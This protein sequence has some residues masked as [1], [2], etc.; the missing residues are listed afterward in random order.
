MPAPIPAAQ[1]LDNTAADS[2]S[3]EK[4]GQIDPQ[5]VPAP[6]EP[7]PPDRPPPDTTDQQE[8]AALTAALAEAGIDAADSDK[9]AVQALARLDAATVETVTN[10]LKTK[11]KD[12]PTK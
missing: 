9:A 7:P 4:M 12:Q 8:A 3:L 5:P 1:R 11:K 10:W 2:R 6:L